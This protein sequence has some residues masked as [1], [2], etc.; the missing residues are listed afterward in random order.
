[1]NEEVQRAGNVEYIPT[2]DFHHRHNRAFFWLLGAVLPF[3]NNALFRWLFGWAMP[4][5]YDLVKQLGYSLVVPQPEVTQSYF[6]TFVLQ[7]YILK[8]QDLKHAL[9]YIDQ[10]MNIYP[11]WLCPAKHAVRSGLEQVSPFNPEEYHVDIGVY[12]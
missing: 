5:R 9:Q 11:I 7:D 8:L 3:A 1:M 6:N 12:G 10:Q 4:P 2:H